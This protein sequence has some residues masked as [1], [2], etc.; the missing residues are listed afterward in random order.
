MI[1]VDMRTSVLPAF[2]HTMK[3]AD[4]LGLDRKQL[5]RLLLSVLAAL[6][7]TI[8]V[9]VVTSLQVL[10]SQG[11]LASYAWFA[12]GAGESTFQSTAAA[13]RNPTNVASS[14]WAWIALGAVS[15]WLIVAGR[16]R[17]LWFPLHPLGYLVAPSYP[18]TNLWFPCFCGWLIKT[19]TMKY[20]GNTA[21]TTLRP[22]MIGLILGN[23]AAMLFWTLVIFVVRGTPPPYW[24]A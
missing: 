18:I 21:Y 19:L 15:V 4:G 22:F 6:I 14:N 3:F 16:S 23:A 2:L 17:F 8:F 24:P 13:I 5:Q 20:G 10:Y 12:K 7:V 1:L 11:G 9:T